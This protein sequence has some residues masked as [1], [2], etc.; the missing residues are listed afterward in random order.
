M[1]ELLK[2]YCGPAACH[3]CFIA[4]QSTLQWTLDKVQ[5][6]GWHFRPPTSIT[7]GKSG[8]VSS[9]LSTTLCERCPSPTQKA[10]HVYCKRKEHLS[11][12]LCPWAKQRI[13]G[14]SS[15]ICLT[16]L[17]M[18]RPHIQYT[19]PGG[20]RLQG[21][22][23]SHSF[24]SIRHRVSVLMQAGTCLTVFDI[25]IY[26]YICFSMY[27]YISRTLCIPLMHSCIYLPQLFSILTH[28]LTLNYTPWC[29]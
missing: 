24:I 27:V 23:H 12:V 14:S 1:F 4:S 21:I 3:S 11:A 25:Y 5:G 26:I 8:F 28:A 18:N 20:G 22:T 13:S 17:T 6:F 9:L 15:N 29:Q 7:E 10:F 2:A 19:Q 16:I